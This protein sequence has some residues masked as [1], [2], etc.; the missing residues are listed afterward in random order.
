[1]SFAQV[2]SPDHAPQVGVSDLARSAAAG[3]SFGWADE[4]AGVL[5]KWMQRFTGSTEEFRAKDK[6]F[7]A[8]HPWVPL[9]RLVMSRE[10]AVETSTRRLRA[11]CRLRKAWDP[12]LQGA[13]RGGCSAV[14]QLAVSIYLHLPKAALTGFS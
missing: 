7:S 10:E 1:M 8:E 2:T 5:P 4:G 6:A 9:L 3:L 13:F 14:A 12:P 11:A